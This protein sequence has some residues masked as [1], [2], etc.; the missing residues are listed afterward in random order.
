V[1]LHHVRIV[2]QP[3]SGGTDVDVVVGGGRQAVVRVLEDP[4]GLVQADEQ[5]GAAAGGLGDDPLSAR[6]GAGPV[7]QVLGAEQL[8]ADRA[9]EKLVGRR[10]GPGKQTR[11]ARRGQADPDRSGL[12]GDNRPAQRVSDELMA[13]TRRRNVALPVRA[14]PGSRRVRRVTAKDGLDP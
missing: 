8:A 6:Q 1:L 10:G 14:T 4:A 5:A 13:D 9:G 3:F 7:A 11:Q 12:A 2:Q